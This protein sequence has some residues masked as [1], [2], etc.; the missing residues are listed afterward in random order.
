M[1]GFSSKAVH[2]G[3]D[4]TAPADIVPPIHM[5]TVYA[6][7][8]AGQPM[9]G[10]EYIRHSNPTR[11]SLEMTLA[12]L[13]GAP[14]DC[15]ALCFS[16]GMAAIDCAFRLLKPGDRLLLTA[17]V[18]GGTYQL[19]EKILKPAGIIV[20]ACNMTDLNA[21]KASL[22][23]PATMVWLESPSNPLIRLTDIGAVSRMA[24][25]GGALVGIDSTF[26]TPCFQQPL[27]LGADIVMHSTTKYIG[28]HS[29][30]LGGAL[31]VRDVALRER[32]YGIQKLTGGVGDHLDA[33][34]SPT[35]LSFVACD[36]ER[37]HPAETR[38]L[39]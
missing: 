22:T 29:D 13:E 6:Y 7:S 32:L 26:G 5:T 25:V 28:G 1:K 24:H 9:L 15:P 12:A 36:L 16:S 20:D 34:Q 35:R 30:L 37:E 33:F 8:A 10:H 3:S 39:V 23:K 38:H 4:A 18:Y 27:S 19:C 31:I 21:V 11:G 17:D 2:A 14:E